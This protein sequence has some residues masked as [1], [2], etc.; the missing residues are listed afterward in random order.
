[1]MLL[2]QIYMPNNQ[3]AFGLPE[4]LSAEISEEVSNVYIRGSADLSVIDLD[5]KY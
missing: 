4:A 3:T 5:K 1:M 2:H